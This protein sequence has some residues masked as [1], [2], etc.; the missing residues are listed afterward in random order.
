MRQRQM[1][2][3]PTRV[4]SMVRCRPLRRRG[5]R[6]VQHTHM[7]QGSRGR[8]AGRGGLRNMVQ[9]VIMRGQGVRELQQPQVHGLEP[10]VRVVVHERALRR[11][12]LCTVQR[13]QVCDSSDCRTLS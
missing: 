5:L 13:P 2:P 3:R 11:R 10:R 4:R 9:R 7:R 6:A 1:R 12:G 8:R